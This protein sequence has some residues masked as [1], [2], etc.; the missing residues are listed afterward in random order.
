MTAS[1]KS[2]AIKQGNLCCGQTLS[3]QV[4]VCHIVLLMLLVLLVL[5]VSLP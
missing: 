5:L 1:V 3:L 2:S 4:S